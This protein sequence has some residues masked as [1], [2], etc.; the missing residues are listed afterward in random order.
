MIL[1]I[2]AFAVLIVSY[3]ALLQQTLKLTSYQTLFD[4]VMTRY[5]TKSHKNKALTYED[6][7]HNNLM[8]MLMAV[9]AALKK[10][11]CLF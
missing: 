1:P 3:H 11:F 7:A 6:N 5:N 8:V 2:R 10:I 4:V 9:S